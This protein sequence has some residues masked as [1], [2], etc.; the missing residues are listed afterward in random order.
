MPTTLVNNSELSAAGN[1]QARVLRALVA[2]RHNSMKVVPS[3]TRSCHTIVV[4]GGKGGVGRSVVALNLAVALAQ[5]GSS[6]G[7]L[8]ACPNF[9]NIE[10]LCE[11]NGYWNLTHVTQGCRELSDVVLT[12]PAGVRI[13]SGGSCLTA[14]DADPANVPG[15]VVEQLQSFEQE[16]DWLIVDASGTSSTSTRQFAVAADDTLIVTT[17]EP[18]AVAE[19]YASVKRLAATIGPRLGLLVNQ[20]DSAGQAQQILDCLQQAAHSFLHVDLHR[21]GYIPLDVAVS[22]SVKTRAP[23]VLQSPQSQAAMAVQRLIQRWNRAE[24]G[25]DTSFFS[26]LHNKASSQTRSNQPLT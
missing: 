12:G 14:Q 20:S 16:L 4:S 15:H 11:L 23:F 13:L 26:R 22:T 21:R 17:P 10:L 18:T 5:R 6:V 1:D 9:G 7:L 8:D 25:Q 24:P 19:A 2:H 3:T